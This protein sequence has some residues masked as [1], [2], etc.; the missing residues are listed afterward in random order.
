MKQSVFQGSCHVRILLPLPKWKC[1][2]LRKNFF[3]GF[4][5]LIVP[6]TGARGFAMKNQKGEIPIFPKN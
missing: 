4:E 2:Q 3:V 1:L 5:A 6:S